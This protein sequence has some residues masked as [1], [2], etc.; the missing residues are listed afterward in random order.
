MKLLP[1]IASS[2]GTRL[3]PVRPWP[4]FTVVSDGAARAVSGT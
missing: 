3:V 2:L 1:R 4:E